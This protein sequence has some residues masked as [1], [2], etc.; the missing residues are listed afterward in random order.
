MKIA[1][2]TVQ[3]A[4][5]RGGAELLA[6]ELKKELIKVGH[7]AEV[8]TMPFV[9][10][11]KRDLTNHIAA[12]R[13]MDV[14]S[15]WGGHIDLCI[16][17]KFP[18]YFMPHPNK[19]LWILH[20]H[21]MMYDLYGKKG[22]SYDTT[23]EI[24]RLRGAVMRADNAYIPEAKK[25]FTIS[26]NVS[27]RLMKFNR[28]ESKPL[29]HPCPGM[30]NFYA[31][32]YEDYLLMPSRINVT[33]RQ[34]LALEALSLC[35]EDVKIYFVGRGDTQGN[36]EIFYDKVRQYKLEDRI[37]AFNY[38]PEEQKLELYAN[39]RGVIF[40]PLDED[41]GYITLEGMAASK[42]VITAKDSGGPL[43]F[44]KDGETGLIVEPSAQE[45]AD[46]MDK[47]WQ[48]KMLAKTMGQNG[49]QRILDMDISW[50]NVI[51][52]LTT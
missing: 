46:A 48:D 29:Y 45:L 43:E 35:K 50:E 5:V 14:R 3:I 40:I 30:N 12:A 32:E 11:R 16:G 27:D 20:Q 24:D 22:F 42:P 17:L 39:A 34:T 10:F 4:F 52:G 9:D 26:Q 47:L 25:K 7:E 19:V 13:L 23:P 31:G 41:Y 21:R 6:E 1:I 36:E 44:V 49:K 51:K 18:A 2:T 37:K 38:V 15:S 8:I 28:I 33:K